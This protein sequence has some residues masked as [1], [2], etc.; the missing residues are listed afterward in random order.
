M[1]RLTEN[2]P[3]F[4]FIDWIEWEAVQGVSETTMIIPSIMRDNFNDQR[5]KGSSRACKATYQYQ[6]DLWLGTG[7]RFDK[8]WGKVKSID[9]DSANLPINS[10]WF[11]QSRLEVWVKT[12][13]RQLFLPEFM[14]REIEELHAMNTVFTNA[15]LFE[16]AEE[17]VF[18]GNKP[19][20][21]THEK[22][23][24][25]E[26]SKQDFRESRPKDPYS[27]LKRRKDKDK[28]KTV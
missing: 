1:R 20:Q 22:K 14:S 24:L 3:Y 8:Y 27:T 5:K 12:K 4:R 9:V 18:F 17:Y 26:E 11:K 19:W 15:K 28:F 10:R 21:R 23:T 13:H 7:I 2:H 25:I 6:I 16:F